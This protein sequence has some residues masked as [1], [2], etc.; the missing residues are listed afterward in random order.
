M[1]RATFVAVTALLIGGCGIFGG[2]EEVEE[3]CF[4]EQAYQMERLNDRIEV[5]EGLDNLDEFKEMPIPTAETP[6]RPEGS[7]CITTP[8]SVRSE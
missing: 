5:P 3:H 2:D 4:E 6:P 1:T 8:P 7:V